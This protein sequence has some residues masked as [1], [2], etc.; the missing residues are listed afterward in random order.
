MG[1]RKKKKLVRGVLCRGFI[2]TL[3]SDAARGAERKS[4]L[5]L[6][7]IAASNKSGS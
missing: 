4:G 2:I 6:D 7:V 5:S 3:K 1:P